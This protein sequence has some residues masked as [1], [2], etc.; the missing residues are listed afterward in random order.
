MNSRFLS[1]ARARRLPYTPKAERP[2]A[3]A[4]SSS[5]TRPRRPSRNL[6]ALQLELLQ[7]LEAA[8]FAGRFWP[9]RKPPIRRL[10]LANPLSHVNIFISFTDASTLAGP[11]LEIR[12]RLDPLGFTPDTQHQAQARQ[13]LQQHFAPAVDICR[14]ISQLQITGEST[15]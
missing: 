6:N 12:F 9:L 15:Q 7:Q 1:D 5:A 13:L 3:Q 2:G 8:G 14:Q 10:Y 11:Q 4:P